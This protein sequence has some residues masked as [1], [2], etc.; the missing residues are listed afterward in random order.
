M[1]A[2]NT[3]LLYVQEEMIEGNNVQNDAGNIQRKDEVG[4]GVNLTDEHNDFLFAD[5]SR[6]EEIKELS[7]N[8]CLMARIQPANFDSDAGP[9][10]DYA[11]L[12]KVQTPSTSYEDPLFAKDNQD[13]KYSKKPKAINS[14]IGDDQIDSNIVFDEPNDDV[15]S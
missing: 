15:N 6:M 8:I 3:R 14:T 12:S 2:E 11:F 5:A 4:V 13:Q 7:A 1:K 9:S 10:Y